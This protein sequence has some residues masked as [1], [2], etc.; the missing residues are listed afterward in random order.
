MRQAVQKR[1]ELYQNKLGLVP[2]ASFVPSINNQP[3]QEHLLRSEGL[4]SII[5]APQHRSHE[6]FPLQ[7]LS[8]LFSQRVPANP[9]LALISTKLHDILGV[10]RGR[11]RHCLL[12]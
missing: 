3:G 11:W 1:R 10:V 4:L 5:C 12:S 6:F 7:Q 8:V 2:T 9:L